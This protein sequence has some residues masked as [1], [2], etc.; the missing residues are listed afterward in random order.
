MIV[1]PTDLTAPVFDIQSFSLQD[2]PGIRTTIFFKGC[3]LR[4]LWCHNPESYLVKPQIMFR[5]NLCTGCLAC[6]AVCSTGA[7]GVVTQDG[8]RI[9]VLDQEKCAACGA[10][11]EVCCYDA[12][13][14]L[15][16]RYTP[17]SLADVIRRDIGYYKLDTNG[18]QGGITLSG[19]E[20]MLWADFLESFVK[21]LP[22]VNVAMET[23]GQAK[24][25][26]YLR[27]APNINLFLFDYKATDPEKHKKLC[28]VDNTL[29]L[30]N[31][32]TLYRMGC[33]IVLRLPLIPGVNDDDGHLRGI[34][35]LLA[36]HPRIRK[37]EIMAYHTLGIGKADGLGM[38]PALEGLPA[39]GEE[40]KRAWLDRLHALGA[41]QVTLSR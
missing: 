28:G 18:Q 30:H 26:S 12:L 37:A 23:S 38:V 6:V 39:A 8:Q 33:D 16:K 1:C 3:P 20:P 15:G 22:G 14:L 36:S 17:R 25:E 40:Q 21:L 4:C 5:Q 31:L 41:E 34:A 10:C 24:T 7:Q 35:A 29:I 9:H 27:L 32:E 2:G 11:L 19:G 13:E